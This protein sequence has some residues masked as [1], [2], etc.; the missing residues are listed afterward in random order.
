MQKCV[1]VVKI[2]GGAWGGH[3]EHMIGWLSWFL[4]S[5]IPSSV[6]TFIL[7]AILG[8]VAHNLGDFWYPAGKHSLKEP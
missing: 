3:Y 8:P 4:I 1:V 2:A 7:P 6:R 5:F